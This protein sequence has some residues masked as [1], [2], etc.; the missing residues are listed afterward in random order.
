MR[1]RSIRISRTF[2]QSEKMMNGRESFP[3]LSFILLGRALC[4]EV[5]CGNLSRGKESGAKVSGGGEEH[6]D[7]DR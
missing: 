3:S 5:G 7:V 4:K 6:S 2:E 1:M